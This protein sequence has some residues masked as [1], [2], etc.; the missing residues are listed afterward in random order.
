MIA[1]RAGGSSSMP[2]WQDVV[3]ALHDHAL[4]WHV[5]RLAVAV[6]AGTL[7]YRLA[8][9]AHGYWIPLTTLAVLQ[10][11][12]HATDV[13]SIQRA[14]G[15]IVAALLVII[16]TVLTEQ[17]WPLV[18]CAGATA[19]LI[20]AL[21]ER[22]YFWLVVMVTPTA[23]LMLSAVRF[24]GRHRRLRPGLQQLDRHRHRPRVRRA[25]PS[26]S[27]DLIASAIAA[28]SASKA[29]VSLDAG[30][31][32]GPGASGGIPN[33]SLSPCTTSTGTSHRVELGQARLLRPAGR[34]DG[35]GEAE[36]GDRAGLLGRAARDP[37]AER[38]PADDQ[39]QA[40][41]LVCAQPL[42]HGA[43]GRVQL[44][45]GRRRA[46]ARDTVGLLDERDR[47]ALLQRDLGCDRRGQER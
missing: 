15:T 28:R 39:R 13:R 45:G 9:L 31:R 44:V 24:R 26:R 12:H 1:A 43:P 33:G 42:E 20:Y 22:G 47:D 4:F 8:D 11:G 19:F 7:V 5:V 3:R 36:D 30:D 6:S 37:R 38:A 27:Q 41:E 16:I 35:E 17:R 40:R 10:P 29:V 14:A 25:G 21:R 32:R 18:A 2:A 46:P 23:L 34:M